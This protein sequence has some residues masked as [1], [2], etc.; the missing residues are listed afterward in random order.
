ME[1]YEV[2]CVGNFTKDT[3]IT[4]R[5]R[6]VVPG[7]GFNYGCHA[8]HALGRKTA[9]VTRLAAEDRCVVEALEALGVA[10]HASYCE[11]STCLTLHYPSDDPDERVLTVTNLADPIGVSHVEAIRSRAFVVGS[12]FRGEVEYEALALMAEHAELLSI[13]VQGFVRVVESGQIH[14]RSWPEL[15]RILALASV[16]KTDS[17]EAEFLTGCSDRRKA[18]R[19]LA[20][21]G[22]REV[23]LTHR[24]GILLFDGKRFYEAPFLSRSIA[25]RS[26]RGDT[27]V[28]AYVAGRLDADP[29]EAIRWSAALTSLKLETPGPFRG[30]RSDVAKM[31]EECY[32]R[33]T[34]H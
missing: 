4:A 30:T 16:L 21:R 27:C 10:V 14:Y 22:A 19:I 18:C 8:A 28:A 3:I 13:D 29:Q 20:E 32:R 25:G 15:E 11:H 34:P 2:T 31:V 12:S 23:L 5:G 6:S 26:G 7:G 9:A 17:S 33:Q 24:D 1:G